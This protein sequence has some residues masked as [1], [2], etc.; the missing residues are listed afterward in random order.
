MVLKQWGK[1]Y[2]YLQKKKIKLL[3]KYLFAYRSPKIICQNNLSPCSRLELPP[4]NRMT[5]SLSPLMSNSN[6]SLRKK[7]FFFFF[8]LKSDLSTWLR[9]YFLQKER[10]VCLYVG[11]AAIYVC[12]CLYIV[13]K[14][15]EWV[16]WSHKMSSDVSKC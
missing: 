12:V 14:I 2:F 6:W 13:T 11:V 15:L 16:H 8:T 7:Y 5:M 1:V 3:L 4:S 9:T 10:G